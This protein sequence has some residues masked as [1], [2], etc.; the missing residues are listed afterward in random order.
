MSRA[1]DCRA[2]LLQA[3]PPSGM[4]PYTYAATVPHAANPP[5]A[6]AGAAEA[7]A[8]ETSGQSG[9]ESEGQEPPQARSLMGLLAS[10]SDPI[11]ATHLLFIVV[12]LMW[13][14]EWRARLQTLR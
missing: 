13:D 12:H 7:C 6:A 14:Q 2:I 5:A 3:E 10:T 11:L 9:E 1:F 4:P 8:P